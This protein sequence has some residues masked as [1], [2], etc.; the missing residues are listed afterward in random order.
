MR[1]F[2]TSYP[3]NGSS[4]LKPE[5]ARQARGAIIEFPGSRTD[6]RAS[7]DQRASR[8]P[9]HARP[10]YAARRKFIEDLK[11]DP[12]DQLDAKSEALLGALFT[13][14]ATLFV[15]LGM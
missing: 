13:G 10:E 7:A 5:T 8:I 2:E 4:A 1:N 6:V 3:T 14:V 12:F 9:A 11:G 15:I